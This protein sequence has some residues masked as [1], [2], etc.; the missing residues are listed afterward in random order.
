MVTL[1]EA[2]A[3]A[4]AHHQA[5]R[6]AAAAQ[7]YRQ[8]LDVEPNH[9]D[10]L[11]LLGVAAHLQGNQPL[12][13]DYIRRA[14]A[15]KPDAAPFHS[16]LGLCYQALKQPDRAIACWRRAVELEPDYA[17]ALNNLGTALTEQGKLDEATACCR[18]AIEL[19]PAFAEAHNSLGIALKA[20]GKLEEAVACYQQVLVLKPNYA[21]ACNNLANALYALGD[22][23]AAEAC[24]RRALTLKP[25]YAE[26][27]NNLGNVLRE[28]GR[29]DE[30]GACWRR[31]L[32][33]KPDYA[34]AHNNAGNIFREQGKLEEAFACY[35]RA[36]L[37]KP[38]YPLAHGNLLAAMQYRGDIT[39]SALAEAHAEWDRKHAAPLRAAWRSHENVRD[40]DRRLRLGFVSPDFGRHPVGYFLIRA[41]ENLDRGQCQIVAYSDRKV[42]DDF[43]P[44]F[45]AAAT[46]WQ[47]VFGRSDEQ[48]AEQIRADAVDILFDLSGHTA[49]NRLLVFARKPAPIQISWIGY[50][51]TTGLTAMDYL[52]ADR[53]VVS[54]GTERYYQERVLRLP[55]G[56]VCYEP[57]SLAPPVG[58]LPA[59]DAGRVT[60]GSFNNPAKITPQVVAVWAAIL[61]RVAGSRLVLKYRGLDDAGTRRHFQGLFAEHGVAADR[62]E[63]AGW[64]DFADMLQQYGRLDVALDPF[65]FSGSATTC[66]ALWMGVPVITC[67]GETFASRHSLSHLSNIGLLETIAGDHDQ[68]V[69]L[70]V[71][72]AGDLPRLAAIRAGLRSQMAAGALCDGSRLARNLMVC[73]R[74]VWRQWV[75]SVEEN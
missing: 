39:L 10:A 47:V 29:L 2:L 18:R 36:L 20:Q 7:I 62:L 41:W 63:L 68:Y 40:P 1:R 43:T 48:L 67:P 19:Q 5:G 11:H 32:E 14:L 26:G 71:G 27:F 57:S 70:A 66:E 17:D 37:E 56:Y 34:E 65:P 46:A 74:D 38:D 72:L 15:V 73:L 16:N 31:A 8:I 45:Q 52:L 69:D 51:G 9:P 60:F 55:E 54:P 6:I 28:L 21:E 61:G 59:L 12:A 35:R 50:E 49:S 42:E 53:F 64:S 25:D 44:R 24:Y 75:Q 4:L 22:L 33:I 13:M 30:A 3:I 58:P 23:D